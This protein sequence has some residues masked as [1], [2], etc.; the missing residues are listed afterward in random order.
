M[1]PFIEKYRPTSIDDILLQEIYAIRLREIKKSGEIPNT[2]ITGPPGVGKTT[3]INCIVN[4]ILGENVK[5]NLLEIN[6]SDERGKTTVEISITNFCSTKLIGNIKYKIII[7]DEAD[8]ITI[9]AQNLISILMEKYE[10]KIRFLFTCNDQ[11]KIIEEIQS[12]CLILK[13]PN[14]DPKKIINRLVFICNHEKIKFTRDSL[15]EITKISKGDVRT[16]LNTLQIV[17]D[18]YGEV[19]IENLYKVCN[20][21]QDKVISELLS[22]CLNNNL[23]N[24][25]KIYNNIKYNGGYTNYDILYAMLD[26][27]NNNSLKIPKY[28]RMKYCNII[29]KTIWQIN[30]CK[31]SDTQFVGCIAELT[32]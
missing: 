27:I 29:G 23:G 28:I 5:E 13:Y 11:S 25:L 6:A 14:V 22:H 7:L 16:S 31:E 3:T 12:K 2:L 1:L 10:N 32:M 24:A 21:P 26:F 20:K 4:D 9:P 17:S 15:E 8:N 30:I 18:A 19:T